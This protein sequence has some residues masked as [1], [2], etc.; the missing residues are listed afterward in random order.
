MD[1]ELYKK[2]FYKSPLGYALHKIILDENENPVDYE[3]IDV[4]SSFE[5]M[6]GLNSQNIIGKSVTEVLPGIEN[7]DFNWIKTYGDVALNGKEIEFEQ[8]S[9]NLNK[10]YKVYAYSPSK[11]YFIT[12][13]IDITSLKEIKSNFHK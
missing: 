12:T 5:R 11:Y 1:I 4:N 3:F 7:D 10:F 2:M 13:F 6:T 9:K 8:Y